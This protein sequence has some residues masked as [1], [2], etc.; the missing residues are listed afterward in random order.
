MNGHGDEQMGMGMNGILKGK[1]GIKIFQPII[2]KVALLS[3]DFSGKG[4][5][6]LGKM[7]KCV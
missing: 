4:R 5:I 1:Q 7:A 3:M 6:I 2:W